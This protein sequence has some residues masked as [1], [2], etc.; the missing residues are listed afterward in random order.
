MATPGQLLSRKREIKV[1]IETTKGTK[2]AGDQ[3]ILVFDLVINPT[4]PF[5]ERKGT[6]LYRGHKETGILEERSG[7]C[8]FSAELRGTAGAFEAG[9]AILLQACGLK[10]TLEVCQV[11]SVPA[12]DKTISID[13]WE[14]G[15]KKGLAGASGNV[16]FEGVA[17]KRMMCNFEFSGIW[18]AVVAE[19]LPAYAPSSDPPM[20]AQGGTFTLGG[21]SIKINS[22]SL[23]MGCQV[24]MRGDFD[25]VGGIAHYHITDY[26]T[27]LSIDPEADLVANYDFNGLWLAGTEVAVSL[28]LTDGTTNITIA[29]AKV[30][31]RE[32]PGGDRDGV[33]TYELVG[34]CNHDS[35]NDSVVIT[36]AAA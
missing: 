30:Q 8:T 23:N 7:T 3:A 27:V 11:H 17:G 1:K 19:A 29:L 9:I 32:I 4:A 18:Q 13:V 5:S 20:R 2:V 10:K 12:E 24:V 36:A 33:L 25:G 35:G 15:V 28:L 14:D 6:G 34:Q 16:T 21:E 26:D 31:C 22:F